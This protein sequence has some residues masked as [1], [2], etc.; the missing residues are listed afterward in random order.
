MGNTLY[1]AAIVLGLAALTACAT[2]TFNSTWKAPDAQP[3]GSLKGQKVVAVVVAKNLSTRRS[4]EDALAAVLNTNGAQGIASYTIVG[5]D[6]TQDEAKAKAAIEKTGAVAV[7]VMRPVSKEKEISSTGRPEASKKAEPLGSAPDRVPAV[8]MTPHEN[9][10]AGAGPS[11]GLR[12][13]LQRH[14]VVLADDRVS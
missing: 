8:E 9:L 10:E 3:L 14:G 12:A 5:E 11:A 6:I 7:V 13:E 2:T 4:A 1:R